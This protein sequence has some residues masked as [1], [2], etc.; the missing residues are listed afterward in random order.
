MNDTEQ[1]NTPVNVPEESKAFRLYTGK[2]PIFLQIVGGLMWLQGLGLILSGIPLL[3]LFGL[4]IIPIII[5]V[6]IIK[7]AKAVFKMQKKGY[8][9]ALILQIFSALVI[10]VNWF[11]N[12]FSKL[13]IED[14]LTFAFSVIAIAVIYFYRNK[15]TEEISPNK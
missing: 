7:Y 2:A 10:I 11:G 6:L 8:K 4:G 5:G 3:L 9:A 12:K 1:E 15:F 14:I 13:A